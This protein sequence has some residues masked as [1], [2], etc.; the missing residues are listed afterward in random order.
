LRWQTEQQK[1]KNKKL[2]GLKWPLIDISNAT[3]NQKHVGM[4]EERKAKRFDRGGA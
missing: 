3:T 1:T 4:M 2:C